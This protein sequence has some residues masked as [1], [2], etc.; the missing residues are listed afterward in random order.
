MMVFESKVPREIFGP[1]M[2]EVRGE[3][4]KLRKEKL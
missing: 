1:E 2:V 4:N 3:G